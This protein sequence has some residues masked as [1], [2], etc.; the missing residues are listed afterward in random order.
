[1]QASG[2]PPYFGENVIAG[3][4]NLES[5]RSADGRLSSRAESFVEPADQFAQA[6]VCRLAS[7]GAQNQICGRR[8]QG[9]ATL[10]ERMRDLVR[11]GNGA[12]FEDAETVK[13]INLGRTVLAD[14]AQGV[15][16]RAA[17]QGDQHGR[18]YFPHRCP[19]PEFPFASVLDPPIDTSTSPSN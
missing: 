5:F 19:G 8:K 9:G 17:V 10:Q 11:S 12:V 1:M 6:R 4:S 3:C 18:G 16:C 2:P 7:G 13:E 14:Q 15:N